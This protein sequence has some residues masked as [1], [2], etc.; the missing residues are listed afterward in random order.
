MFCANKFRDTISGKEKAISD[1]LDVRALIDLMRCHVSEISI[2]AQVQS[3][4][5]KAKAED[6]LIP[7][8]KLM[9]STSIE[10][11]LIKVFE[12]LGE[13]GNK[14]GYTLE[15]VVDGYI[16]KYNQNIERIEKDWA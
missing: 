14:L 5:E 3:N 12:L 6:I 4:K 7:E 8:Y 15:Q 2:I 10:T 11:R 13:I 1:N 9:R 16:D